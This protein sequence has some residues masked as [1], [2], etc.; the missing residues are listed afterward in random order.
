MTVSKDV[1]QCIL[2]SN[3]KSD[4]G[5]RGGL[6]DA[7]ARQKFPW[8]GIAVE[9]QGCRARKVEDHL[10]AGVILRS[11]LLTHTRWVPV[12]RYLGIC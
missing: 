3:D 4:A 10:G 5:Y 7:Q 11:A 9:P 12:S 8:R 1:R 6:K 2:A